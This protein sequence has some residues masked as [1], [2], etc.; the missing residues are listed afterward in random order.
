MPATHLSILFSRALLG[1]RVIPVSVEIH[2]G[3]GLP[4]FNMVGLPDTEVRE[5]RERVRV[6]L[7][8]N[9]FEFPQR[10]ITVNLAPAD[11][12]KESGRFDLPIALGILIASQQIPPPVKNLEFAGELALDG[13]L[14]PIRG[15]L[16]MAV[17]A[18]AEGRVLVLPSSSA[19]EARLHLEASIHSAPSLA[20]V[21]AHIMGKQTLSF[22]DAP[23]RK[24]EHNDDLTLPDLADIYGQ[25]QACM[26]L[27]VAAAGGHS[28]LFYGPP[29]CGKT[30]LAERLPGILPPMTQEEALTSAV[31]RSLAGLP[32]NH[33]TW[34]IRPFRRPHHTTPALAITGGGNPIR[35]GE[36]SLAHQGVLFLDE[37]PEFSRASLE[38]L[39]EPLES[40]EVYISRVAGAEVL[41]AKFQLLATMNPCPCGRGQDDAKPCRCTEAKI[42]AYRAR[43]SAPILDRIDLWVP[44]RKEA[45]LHRADQKPPKVALTSQKAREK[46][47]QSRQ[48]QLNR[49]GCENARLSAR[50]LMNVASLSSQVEATWHHIIQTHRLSP[51]GAHRLLK[52]A[53]TLADLDQIPL[54]HESHLFMAAQWR[55]AF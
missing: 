21:C 39:R 3:N 37:L 8:A 36:I 52:V 34:K 51:R 47:I 45:I 42:Q 1:A 44:V 38:A 31:N 29:G 18:H 53:R 5:S 23:E 2:V 15:G 41:P 12:P 24:E 20:A 26:A 54:I 19:Q 22:A 48:I 10:R 49:Q 40:G 6:A 28:L 13:Q 46:V 17:A 14:R 43:V 7:L 55:A 27:I 30:L 11:L 50:N 9:G 35:P 16:A 33:Q 25:E 32:L 4:Q